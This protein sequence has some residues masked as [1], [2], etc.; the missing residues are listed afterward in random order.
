MLESVLAAGWDIYAPYRSVMGV[1]IAP[2]T[3][4]AL[5]RLVDIPNP[6]YFLHKFLP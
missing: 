4:I 6:S 3:L 1:K 2:P 5:G